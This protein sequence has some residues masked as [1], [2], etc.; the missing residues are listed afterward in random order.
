MFFPA[1]LSTVDVMQVWDPFGTLARTLW[2]GGAQWAGKST[3]ARLLAHRYGLTAYHHDYPAARSHLD[4]Y[5]LA[6]LRRGEP[7]P[8]TDDE[9]RWVDTTPERM[10]EECRR[11]WPALFDYALDDLRGL[12]GG[13]PVLA[14]GWALRPELVAPL[15]DAPD[16]MAVMVPSPAFVEHQTRVLDRAKKLAAAVSDP[17]RAQGNRLARDAILAAEAV[18]AARRLG[19]RVFTVD[20]TRDAGAMADELADHFARHLPP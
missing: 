5:A 9:R 1:D 18:A 15:L 6:A 3:V 19:I 11:G 17:R 16:R 4:R 13:R 14:E 10:A 8:I 2:L 7:D 20:G 12:V